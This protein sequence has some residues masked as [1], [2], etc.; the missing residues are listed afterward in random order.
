MPNQ[1]SN[2]LMEARPGPEA[3]PDF[4][5]SSF[6]PILLTEDTTRQFTVSTQKSTHNLYRFGRDKQDRRQVDQIFAQM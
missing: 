6:I 5:P 4:R 3:I 1:G 2:E